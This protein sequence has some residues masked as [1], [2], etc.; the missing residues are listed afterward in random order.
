MKKCTR[1]NKQK[2]LDSFQKRAASKDGLTAS[3]KQ[4]LSVYDKK[5]AKLPHRVKLRIDY[6]KSEAGIKSGNKAKQLWIDRNPIK[7]N[8]SIIARNAVRD[9]R[10]IKPSVC[11]V[12]ESEPRILHGHHD[13][14]ALPL[15]VR[16]L[17]PACHTKWH[18]ENGQGKNAG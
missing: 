4:C 2:S 10:L 1:C 9:G 7:R 16:W 18:K 17:C 3:C 14:Y 5:R 12:C 8:A 15:V 13:D 11:E 6:S